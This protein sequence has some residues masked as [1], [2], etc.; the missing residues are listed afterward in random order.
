VKAAALAKVPLKIRTDLI[1]GCLA[2]QIVEGGRLSRRISEAV[3]IG[4]GLEPPE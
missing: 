2:A 3:G 1:G 4:G